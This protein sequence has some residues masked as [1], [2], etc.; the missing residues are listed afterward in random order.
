MSLNLQELEQKRQALIE[1]LSDPNIGPET[2]AV[3]EISKQLGRLEKQIARARQAQGTHTGHAVLEIYAGAGGVDAQDWTKMLL[4]MYQA[5]A[6]KQ[7]YQAT[8]LEASYGEQGG[9]KSATLR[10]EGKEAYQRLKQESGVHRLVRRSPF[11]AK[12]LRHTSFAMVEVL[13]ELQEI[14]EINIPEKDLRIDTYRASGPGGQFVNRR[15]TAVRIT[16]LP[17]GLSAASQ[18]SRSQNQNREAAMKLLKTKLLRLK[19]EQQAETL[20]Q[21]KPKTSPA[22]GNQI[23]SYILDPYELVKDHRSGAETSQV[24]EVLAGNLELVIS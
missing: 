23:R 22:W 24:R 1:K 20:D 7:G 5:W 16:H 10:I 4:E 18:H 17:T 21:L 2:D 11:S 19:Q 12:R 9:L 15:E 3:S 13:P 6:K 14:K 8:L